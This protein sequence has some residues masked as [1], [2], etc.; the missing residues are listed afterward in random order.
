MTLQN[1]LVH[2]GKGYLWT[3]T[4]LWDVRSGSI[5]GEAAKAFTGTYWPWAAVLSGAF[6]LNAL[7]RIPEII[8]RAMPR[9]V[10]ELLEVGRDALALEASAGRFSRL[11]FCVPDA[12]FGAMLHFIAA[13]DVGFA[14][15]F[16]P[17]R[18]VQFTS[19]C[20]TTSRYAEY[21][22]KG[23]TPSLMRKFVGFQERKPEQT[24]FGN[25]EHTIGGN[26]VE[27]EL[28]NARVQ[29]RILRSAKNAPS[30]KTAGEIY[31]PL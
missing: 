27:I 10:S 29:S 6:D 15:P 28:A 12:E 13:D 9:D 21:D 5:V 7:Y 26:I 17:I 16:E 24:V 25:F 8:S 20:G 30:V 14:R 2:E 4:A 22:R 1:G 11:L 31:I 19:S 3:D 23:F 18:T